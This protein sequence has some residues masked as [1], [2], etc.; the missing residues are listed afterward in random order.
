MTSI[1]DPVSTAAERL[2]LAYKN[3][4]IPPLR[5]ILEPVD[6]VRAYR[7]QDANT[8]FWIAQGRRIVGRKI[9][10]TSRAVQ[11]QLGVDQPD[12]GV[13][14]SDMLL[15]DG[16]TLPAPS[17]IAPRVEGEIAFVLATDLGGS[18]VTNANVI[19]ATSHI[20]PAIEIV[21]SRIRDWAIS[22]G[23][24]VADNASGA[25]FVVGRNRRKLTQEFVL[26]DCRMTL[27]VNGIVASK[28]SGAACLGNPLDAMVWLV[29]ALATRGEGLN[30]GDVVMTGALG[31][32]VTIAP[33]DRIEVK[34]SG[35]G[36]ARF[37]LGM[38]EE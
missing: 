14:F 13:L 38:A 6:A 19:A 21:D 18:N 28:G 33:G 36:A 5:D 17:V 9:G 32:M 31:P 15:L 23:D 10:L 29:R 30:A 3:G 22:F 12:F 2:R 1:I 7:V 4:A 20:A 8:A 27:T 26:P 25:F 11:R 24:T 37:S 16:S 35:V 34:I